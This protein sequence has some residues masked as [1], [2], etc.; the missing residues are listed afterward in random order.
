MVSWNFSPSPASFTRVFIMVNLPISWKWMES[1]LSSAYKIPKLDYINEIKF[2]C[3]PVT[4]RLKMLG[5]HLRDLLPYIVI[6][7]VIILFQKCIIRKIWANILFFKQIKN[8]YTNHNCNN[9]TLFPPPS[10]SWR[11]LVCVD[12]HNDGLRPPGSQVDELQPLTWGS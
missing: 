11:R 4:L 3:K 8:H 9:A 12:P 6:N 1:A 2:L 10:R 7:P 5:K